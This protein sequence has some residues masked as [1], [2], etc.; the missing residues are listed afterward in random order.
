MIKRTFPPGHPPAQMETVSTEVLKV[1]AY[2]DADGNIR[3]A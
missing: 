3:Y 1:I 2:C